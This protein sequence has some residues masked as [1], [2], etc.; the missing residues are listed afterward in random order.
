MMSRVIALPIEDGGAGME[1]QSMAQKARMQ[2]EA[3]PRT[4]AR[5]FTHASI[6]HRELDVLALVSQGL[7]YRLLAR[8]LV[9]T[10]RTAS[11][12][13]VT[14]RGKLCAKNNAHAVALAF[15]AGL[16]PASEAQ[17]NRPPL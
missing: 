5:R 13:M 10:P 17:E 14:V 8:M 15:H 16:L 7:T 3:R 11:F 1:W 12:H 4:P 9:I 2:V 6:T